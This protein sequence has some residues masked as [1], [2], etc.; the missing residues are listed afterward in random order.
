MHN[1]TRPMAT[2]IIANQDML[3]LGMSIAKCQ[4]WKRMLP[5]PA[6]LPNLWNMHNPTR[7]QCRRARQQNTAARHK[8]VDL[9][10]ACIRHLHAH[11][12]REPG[13]GCCCLCC[14]VAGARG[15]RHRR[16]CWDEDTVDDV[17]TE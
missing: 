10:D 17:V 6:E 8:R 4:L 15:R 12:R 14:W 13:C 3:M 7:A 9:D 1:P 5:N 11:R 2:S 16:G